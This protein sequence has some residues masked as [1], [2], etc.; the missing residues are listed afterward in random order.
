VTINQRKWVLICSMTRRKPVWKCLNHQEEVENHCVFISKKSCWYDSTLMTPMQDLCTSKVKLFLSQN[1]LQNR[2]KERKKDNIWNKL[3][4]NRDSR[5][6]GKTFI[7]FIDKVIWRRKIPKIG[8]IFWRSMLKSKLNIK[9]TYKMAESFDI[10][11]S[12]FTIL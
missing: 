8:K 2:K 4:L 11:P 5:L 1:L 6:D 12:K 7:V 10:N 9:I 3:L